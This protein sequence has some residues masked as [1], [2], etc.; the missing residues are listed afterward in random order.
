[1]PSPATR[2]PG[3]NLDSSHQTVPTL[4][5]LMEA[6]YCLSVPFRYCRPATSLSLSCSRMECT[7][8]TEDM[9]RRHQGVTPPSLARRMP[10][11]HA[12]MEANGYTTK[13]A[14]LAIPQIRGTPNHL[15][16][17]GCQL[18]TR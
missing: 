4:H 9:L 16:H 10:T 14:R 12:L 6:Y 15:W 17:T 7:T 3:Q 8:L 11:G 18:V 1:M 2:E 5:A 13:S